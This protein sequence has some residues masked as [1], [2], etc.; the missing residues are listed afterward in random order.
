MGAW[1]ATTLDR[2]STARAPLPGNGPVAVVICED[3]AD[4]AAT[5]DHLAG[6]GCGT[7]AVFAPAIPADAAPPGPESLLILCRTAVPG[8]MPACVN[9]VIARAP[10]RWVHFC[11]NG[12]FLFHP[13][14]ETRGLP[15]LLRFV[16]GERRAAVAGVTVDLYPADPAA[17]IVRAGIGPGAAHFDAAG[18]FARDRIGPDGAKLERQPEILGGLRWRMAEHFPPDRRSLDRVAL[19]RA[20]RGLRMDAAGHLS[21]PEL[22]TRSAPWHRS[23]T[24]AV[25][26]TRVARALLGAP[27]ARDGIDGFLWRHAQQFEWRAQQ[28]ME[29]GL[30]EPGQWF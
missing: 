4:I 27:A 21:D 18:Y 6:L 13:F 8:A 3:H 28:L 20:R 11:Y 16:E 9:A 1:H 29:A 26:S 7:L 22:N 23:V 15:E 24:A 2:F 30:M 5:L 14:S 10:G 19:F 25:A 17:G 12:E